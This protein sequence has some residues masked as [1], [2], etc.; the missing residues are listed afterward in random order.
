[1]DSA[2]AMVDSIENP[3]QVQVSPLQV[4]KKTTVIHDNSNGKMREAGVLDMPFEENWWEFRQQDIQPERR[5]YH[6][7]FVYDNRLFVYGGKDIQIGYMDNIWAIDLKDIR[8]FVRG[9][10]EYSPN[11]QWEPIKI[12]G[13]VKPPALSNHSSVVYKS[14]MY[15]FG[16]SSKECENVDMF[17]LDLQLYKWQIVK[18]KADND[19]HENFPRTRDEHSCVLYN[20]SMVVFGGFSFGQR[21]N[22]VY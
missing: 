13:N 8:E 14:K 5:G 4:N 15:L 22:D 6:S 3:A 7:S 11:P 12:S 19:L 18:A 21:T 10:T 9:Q 2:A 16:G 17:T 20:D 1:M